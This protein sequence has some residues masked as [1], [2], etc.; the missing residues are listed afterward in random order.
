[1]IE[2]ITN[3]EAIEIINAMERLDSAWATCGERNGMA[4]TALALWRAYSPAILN[5]SDDAA[6]SLRRAINRTCPGILSASA[7][8]ANHVEAGWAHFDEEPHIRTLFVKEMGR[9]PFIPA[10]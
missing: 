5:G 4:F 6:H 10:R 9:D 1:M 3:P 2:E 8:Y 7:I